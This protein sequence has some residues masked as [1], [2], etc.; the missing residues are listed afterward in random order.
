AAA[1]VA[2]WIDRWLIAGLLGWG[3]AGGLDLAGR[4]LRLA[5]TGNL[6]TYAFAA[7]A[8]LALVLWTMLT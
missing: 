7:A 1:T 5:Q 6:Q 3:A 2:D 4:V 8:G